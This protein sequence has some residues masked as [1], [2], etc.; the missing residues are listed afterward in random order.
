[1]LAIY[2][3]KLSGHSSTLKIFPDT[4]KISKYFLFLLCLSK[5]GISQIGQLTSQTSRSSLCPILT[6]CLLGFVS[7]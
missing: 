6:W 5:I 1:M 4:W 3:N 7:I 2:L